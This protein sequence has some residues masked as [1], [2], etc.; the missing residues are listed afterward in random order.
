MIL[1]IF[2]KGLNHK[3]LLETC[4]QMVTPD[5]AVIFIEDGVLWAHPSNLSTVSLA[6]NPGHLYCLTEDCST[7]GLRKLREDIEETDYDGFV[8]LVAHHEKSISWY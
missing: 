3:S 1:H 7:R 2:S 8:E 5:D 4:L 6:P